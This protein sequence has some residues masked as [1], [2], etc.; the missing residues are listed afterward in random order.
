MTF[1][2]AA[3]KYVRVNGTYDEEIA[4]LI[5]AVDYFY[6]TFL[7][8]RGWTTQT[9]VSRMPTDATPGTD[10]LSIRYYMY[11]RNFTDGFT[12]EARKH[13][14]H[15]RVNFYPVAGAASCELIDYEDATYTT[16]PGDKGEDQSMSW[17]TW[18]HRP[19]Y[20]SQGIY[21]FKFWVSDVNNK[22][23]LVTRGN[24]L[25]LME[26]GCDWCQW[27]S[28]P[29]SPDYETPNERQYNTHIILGTYEHRVTNLPVT[30]G[31]SSTLQQIRYRAHG[32]GRYA[33]P[34][35][36]PPYLVSNFSLVDNYGSPMAGPINQSDVRYYV[37]TVSDGVNDYGSAYGIQTGI[38]FR[39][40][41]INNENYW[42]V[43]SSN[44]SGKVLAYDLGPT[45][46]VLES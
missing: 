46:P 1:Q 22:S 35:E 31:N 21:P 10:G 23:F 7:P 9:H 44:P 40:L 29:R 43:S 28:C 24:R 4:D 27:E 19:A 30:T 36:E 34:A 16:T 26:L 8:A 15:S 13:Y 32:V 45:K 5:E 20:D 41:H 38:E 11:Q 12:G 17:T 14:M 18:L 2:L 3:T 6:L 25:Y 33:G 42:L 39:I 37:G